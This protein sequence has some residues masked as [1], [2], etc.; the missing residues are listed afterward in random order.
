MKDIQLK[1]LFVFVEKRWID[2]TL[3]NIG[4]RIHF[5]AS[6]VALSIEQA[7]LHFPIQHK[8]NII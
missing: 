4:Y 5:K 2:K 6:N 7:I 1:N 8:A 3:L